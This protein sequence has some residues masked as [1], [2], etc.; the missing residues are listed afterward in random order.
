MHK[1]I[2][3]FI[4]VIL[5]GAALAAAK[6]AFTP[7]SATA[8]IIAPG[9]DG[10][11]KCLGGTLTGTFTPCTPGSKVQFR[12]TNET[13]RME[14]SDPLLTGIRTFVFNANFDETGRGHIWGT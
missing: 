3:S 9:S 14:G 2:A 12:G 4:F 5:L 10:E 13:F 6:V 7:V 11:V 8:F 1:K